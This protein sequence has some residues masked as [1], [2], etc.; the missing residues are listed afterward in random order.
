[1]TSPML[2]RIRAEKKAARRRQLKRIIGVVMII[3]G[4]LEIGGSFI[5]GTMP[6][7][8]HQY[9]GYGIALHFVIGLVLTISGIVLLYFNQEEL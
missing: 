7:T 1:M 6:E 2:E 4:L 8:Y 5:F 9:E 3:I